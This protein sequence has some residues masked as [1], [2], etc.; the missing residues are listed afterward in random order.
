M[1]GNDRDRLRRQWFKAWQSHLSG[2]P[3]EP[4]ERQIVGV[5]LAHPEYQPLVASEAGL[6]AEF[7]PEL[8]QTNPFLHMGL[9]LAVR[10]QL[11]LDRP[12][13]IRAIWEQLMEKQTDAH[14]AEHLLIDCLAEQLWL[15][16][17]NGR[18]PD[19]GAYLDCVRQH[20]KSA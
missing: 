8:G 7:P 9:H 20:T 5:L 17:R 1:F 13:G 12:A 11:Q 16:Q 19:E 3:L 6:N 2:R 14:H 10:E 18:P 4:L 15:A